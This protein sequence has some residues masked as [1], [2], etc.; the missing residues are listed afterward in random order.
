[1]GEPGDTQLLFQHSPSNVG[2]SG[3]GINQVT[4]I[5]PRTLIPPRLQ[6]YTALIVK[7]KR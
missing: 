1:M 5:L 3:M 2:P 6:I 7:T 4:K